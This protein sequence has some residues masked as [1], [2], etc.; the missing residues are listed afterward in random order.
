MSLVGPLQ[1]FSTPWR[2]FPAMTKLPGLMVF[3]IC[4]CC[5][6]IPR[7]IFSMR[8]WS[9]SGKGLMGLWIKRWWGSK[10]GKK[11]YPDLV[12][13]G[14]IDS[15]SGSWRTS[16]WCGPSRWRLGRTTWRPG[17]A[18]SRSWRL[19]RTGPGRRSSSSCSRS[20]TGFGWTNWVEGI[21]LCWVTILLIPVESSLGKSCFSGCTPLPAFSI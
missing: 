7:I 2:T 19:W 8:I 21:A 6:S 16:S 13:L 9:S 17:H 1:F 4:I 10:S 11:T 18:S 20:E 12:S 15:C 14:A 3:T 5:E